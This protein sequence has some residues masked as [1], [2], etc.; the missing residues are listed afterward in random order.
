MMSEAT[1]FRDSYEVIDS[2]RIKKKKEKKK[3]KK[4]KEIHEPSLDSSK[5]SLRNAAR[6]LK[7]ENRETML[8]AVL[9]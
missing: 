3:G 1:S 5:G 8:D 9:L 4:R 7:R 2:Y 6:D